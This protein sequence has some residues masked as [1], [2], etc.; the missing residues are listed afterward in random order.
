MALS[1]KEQYHSDSN[2]STPTNSA[3]HTDELNSLDLH[4]TPKTTTAGSQ[5][6]WTMHQIHLQQLLRCD[7]RAWQLI[8]QILRSFMDSKQEQAFRCGRYTDVSYIGQSQ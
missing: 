7:A 4:I 5:A 2:N 6:Q 1:N 8:V 3:E